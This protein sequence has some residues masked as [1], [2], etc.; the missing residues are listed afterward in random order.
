MII[1]LHSKQLT[2]LVVIRLNPTRFEQECGC[3]YEYIDMIIMDGHQSDQNDY[4]QGWTVALLHFGQ[5]VL[6]WWIHN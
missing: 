3:P 2:P 4:M 6:L 1:D 5:F